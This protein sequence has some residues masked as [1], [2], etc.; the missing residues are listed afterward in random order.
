MKKNIM[1]PKRSFRRRKKAP[2]KPGETI[3]YKNVGLLR[4][5]ISEQG[6]LLPRR[7]NRLLSKQQ[8]A[9]TK[10]VKAARLVALLPFVNNEIQRRV[11]K[12]L[13]RK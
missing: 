3:D 10:A 1:R 8:R 2:L 4:K 7:V 13:I 9:M 6:K 12:I 5:F 11:P